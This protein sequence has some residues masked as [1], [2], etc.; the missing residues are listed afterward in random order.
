MDAD[1]IVR[2]LSRCPLIGL[3]GSQAGL[4]AGKL[5]E[6]APPATLL[7]DHSSLFYGLAKQ[8]GIRD[9]SRSGTATPVT[10]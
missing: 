3:T 2:R 8:A 9:P 7:A 10:H 4:D 1:K 5:I 6:F